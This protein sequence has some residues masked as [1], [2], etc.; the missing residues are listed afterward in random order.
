MAR[1]QQKGNGIRSTQLTICPKIRKKL[2]KY[3]SDAKNCISWWQNELEFEVD[4]MY[5]ARRIV[6]LDKKTCTCGGW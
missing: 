1:F 2:E 6:R 4:H 3:K 5:D